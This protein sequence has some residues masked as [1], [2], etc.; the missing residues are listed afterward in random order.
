MHARE[1][2]RKHSYFSDKA[3]GIITGLGAEGYELALQAAITRLNK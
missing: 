3:E 1:E 2:F